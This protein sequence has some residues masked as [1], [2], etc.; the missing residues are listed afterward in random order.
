MYVDASVVLTLITGYP[1]CRHQR[2]VTEL[3]DYF[4]G[5]EDLAKQQILHQYQCL[6]PLSHMSGFDR[7][8]ESYYLQEVQSECGSSLWI[9]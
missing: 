9:S 6:Q 4:G 1:F 7:N 3:V 2:E 8:N 5:N